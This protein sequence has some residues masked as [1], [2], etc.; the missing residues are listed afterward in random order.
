MKKYLLVFVIIALFFCPICRAVKSGVSDTAAAELLLKTARNAALPLRDRLEAYDSLSSMSDPGDLRLICT[1]RG[2]LYRET[3]DY[4]N[5][6]R[7]FHEGVHMAHK[8]SLSL[9][10]D[11]L[12]NAMGAQLRGGMFKGVFDDALTILSMEKPDSL[13]RYDVGAYLVVSDAFVH[14]YNYDKGQEYLEKAK[15][16]M[17]GSGRRCFTP[18]ARAYMEFNILMAEGNVLL[19][20]KEYDKA[21]DVWRKARKSVSDPDMV[22]VADASIGLIFLRQG[23]YSSA[24]SYVEDIMPDMK[25]TVNGPYA[26]L[27]YIYS[28]AGKG[29]YE[30]ASGAVDRYSDELSL[31]SGSSEQADLESVMSEIAEKRG[32]YRSALG[33]LRTAYALLDSIGLVDRTAY[34]TGLDA[35]I[36]EWERN[37]REGNDKLSTVSLPLAVAVILVLI[38]LSCGVLIFMAGKVRKERD[39]CQRLE[40]RLAEVE[41]D[42]AEAGKQAEDATKRNVSDLG[43][44]TMQLAAIN[45][46]VEK[47]QAAA[48]GKLS[49]KE[50]V[51]EIRRSLACLRENGDVWKLFKGYFEEL[52]QNFFDRLYRLHPDL[53]NAETRMCAFIMMKMT[54]KEIASLTSRSPRTVHCIKYNLR[55]KCG[56]TEST[57]GYLRRISSVSDREFE[58]ILQSRRVVENTISV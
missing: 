10:C 33:H 58:R 34:S 49:D 54:T 24:V 13:A 53:T 47:I 31:L 2:L 41:A 5:E 17:S 15:R 50:A 3:R 44:V 32:D 8:D 7:A 6:T 40:S 48:S 23:D 56:I 43:S 28:L 14:L 57:E 42:L 45:E 25:G 35:G 46:A 20:K 21:L 19:N 16:L 37:A 29:D 4:V 26:I 55:Q 51:K 38:L 30:S 22:R 11:L 39:S 52:N 36:Q 9:R 27:N 18:E 1:E 12:L